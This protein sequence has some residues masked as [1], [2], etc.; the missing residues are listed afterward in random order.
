MAKSVTP[1]E[2]V[3]SHLNLRNT[4]VL[5]LTAGGRNPDI[6]GAFDR[7]IKREPRSVVVICTRTGSP[8]ADLASNSGKA[9]LFEFD[10]PTGKDGFL[11]TNSLLATIVSLARAYES[12]G[13]LSPCLPN[14]L[15]DLL[16]GTT[17]QG[18]FL[19]ELALRAAPLWGRSSFVVLNTPATQPAAM[20]LESRFSE[21]AVANT[22][23]TDYRNFAHGRHY[24]LAR[25][26]DTTA[27]IAFVTAEV[28]TLAERT[29]RLLPDCLPVFR[30]DLQGEGIGSALSGIV[31]S[32]H[33]TQFA[34]EALG[35][36][37]GRPVVPEFGRRL[38]HIKAFPTP[39]KRANSI[40]AAQA[41][42]IERKSRKSLQSLELS[43]EVPA[44][45]TAY[46]QFVSTLLEGRFAAVAFDYDGTLCESADRFVGP[47]PEV[48]GHINRLLRE[49]VVV[50]IATGRGKSVKEQLR[51]RIDRAYWRMVPIVYYN[52]AEVGLLEEDDC[53]CADKDPSAPLDT[54]KRQLEHHPIISAHCSVESNRNQLTLIP[55]SA[56]FGIAEI[57]QVAG[58][59]VG[60][61]GF[62]GVR[63]LRS[64]HSVDILKPGASKLAILE[65]VEK[66]VAVGGPNAVLCIGDRGGW[67]G[68]DCD[69]LSGPYSLS[70]EETS[71]DPRTC[72]N[73]ASPGV[74]NTRALVEYLGLL[75]FHHHWASFSAGRF[76]EAYR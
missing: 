59:L 15:Y 5:I 6:L 66:L 1:F 76:A 3:H 68:N 64:D 47:T 57:W 20:D 35:F 10:I 51:E 11:A 75:D 37:P 13:L 74:S 23:V 73:L 60:Q 53:P 67:P 39:P 72:W 44:W 38:Y 2:A 22:Q 25:H 69:L 28:S 17:S 70:V 24:W 33:L 8:L 9:R 62:T 49:G 55:R 46:H 27:V 40:P 58:F 43:A 63:V 12:A 42:A 32:L 16:P 36:D 48:S 52:G 29:L 4:N 19:D 31:Y 41:A 34:G 21:A 30:I 61:G 71:P 14:S 7:L 56:A 18:V 54:I 45:Q 65:A 26:P 50:G